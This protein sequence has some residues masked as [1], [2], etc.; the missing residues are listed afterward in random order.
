M[1][2][3]EKPKWFRV[4][5]G[6][7]TQHSDCQESKKTNEE[8]KTADDICAAPKTGKRNLFSGARI[9]CC[10][11]EQISF[12]QGKYDL[13]QKLFMIPFQQLIPREIVCWHIKVT[14]KAQQKSLWMCGNQSWNLSDDRFPLPPPSNQTQQSWI[15]N[16]HEQVRIVCSS[17]FSVHTYFSVALGSWDR[18]SL[19]HLR[20][21]QNRTMISLV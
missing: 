1:G 9:E 14:E 11:K 5:T 13:K 10:P 17:R 3:D 21:R 12:D 20:R 18:T 19:V 7:L 6:E 4:Q 16:V 8:H 15:P 2:K